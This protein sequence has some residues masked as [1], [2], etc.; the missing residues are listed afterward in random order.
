MQMRASRRRFLKGLGAAI[1]ASG[2][3][4]WTGAESA[5]AAELLRARDATPGEALGRLREDSLLSPDITY[6]NHAS[7][8]TVPR[9]VL[10]AQTRYLALCES[11]PWLYVWGGAWEDGREGARRA[12]A[13][14]LGCAPERIVLTHNTTEGFN[15]LATGLPL[16]PGDEVLFSSLNHDGASVC[17]RQAGARRGYSV[18]QFDFPA[19]L[20]DRLTADEIVALHVDRIGPRT[21]ALVLPHLDN[22]VGIRVPL[23]RLVPEVRERGVRWILVDGAQTIGMVP[24][25]LDDAGVDAYAGSPH[26]WLQSPKGLGVLYLS[27]EVQAELEPLWVTWGQ[28]R[29]SGTQRIFEDYGTRNLAEVLTLEDAVDYHRTLPDPDREARL[30]HLVGTLLTRVREADHLE[31]GSPEDWALGGAL[32]S[33]RLRQGRAGEV[34]R[35]IYRDQGI[36]VR[37]FETL[38]LNALRV[39]PN[40]ITTEEDLDRF[41]VATRPT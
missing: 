34:T 1:G 31:W 29:W 32:V 20:A 7:I 3:Q 11:N 10:D 2:L 28:R 4:A 18:R 22:A 12:V 38:R 16:G 24:L 21:R 36:V 14:M 40:T 25:D 13:S 33:V 30:R 39:S 23:D 17:W 26:K 5:F 8:G 19:D 15:L 35:R 41:V 9:P 27:P 37:G 6:L